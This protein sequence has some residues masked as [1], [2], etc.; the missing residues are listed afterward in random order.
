[1]KANTNIYD[2][3]L[4]ASVNQANG[5]MDPIIKYSINLSLP[6]CNLGKSEEFFEFY[7]IF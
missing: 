1:M 4:V 7:L 6:F 3:K 2:G 5:V